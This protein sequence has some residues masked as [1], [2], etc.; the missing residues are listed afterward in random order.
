[1]IE[2]LEKKKRKAFFEMVADEI[3]KNPERYKYFAW[4]AKN[5]QQNPNYLKTEFLSKDGKKILGEFGYLHDVHND[6]IMAL[7]LICFKEA[8]YTFTKD[9]FTFFEMLDST[10]RNFELEIIPNGLSY[11]LACRAFKRFGFELVGTKSKSVVLL[12]GKRYDVQIWEKKEADEW[13]E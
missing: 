2:L 7:E 4:G 8:S 3:K 10:Y 5:V 11:R 9:L 12:D 1:M 13:E 6:K